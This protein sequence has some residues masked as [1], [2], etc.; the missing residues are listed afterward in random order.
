VPNISEIL[1]PEEPAPVTLP[2]Q[3]PTTAPMRAEGCEEKTGAERDECYYNEAVGTNSSAA[4]EKIAGDER[5]AACLQI[6]APKP[7]EDKPQGYERA[8]CKANYYKSISYC[9]EAGDAAKECEYRYAVDSGSAAVCGSISAPAERAACKALLQKNESVCTEVSGDVRDKCYLLV[10]V[11]KKETYLC[12][13]ITTSFWLSQYKYAT[14]CYIGVA[15]AVG[16]YKICKEAQNDIDRDYC[17][18]QVARA[19]TNVEACKQIKGQDTH[20]GCIRDLAKKIGDPRICNDMKNINGRDRYCYSLIYD[21]A[22][23]RT[24]TLVMCDGIADPRV[25]WSCYSEV[26]WRAQDVG[27]CDRITLDE[28]A[29]RQL[30]RSRITGEEIVVPE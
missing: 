24:L 26:A 28:P 19:L 1:R 9:S 4:C 16:D 13:K 29:I 15:L 20:D 2:A 30:C 14:Q 18:D 11:E 3:Q 21:R 10:A 5:R 25:K 8:L 27:I 12:G 17:Y 7:C 22:A 6:F 23:N